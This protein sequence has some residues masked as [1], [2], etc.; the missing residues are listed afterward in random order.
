MNAPPAVIGPSAVIGHEYL[1]GIPPQPSYRTT[2]HRKLSDQPIQSDPRKLSDVMCYQ[3]MFLHDMQGMVI[4]HNFF[5][6]VSCFRADCILELE[7]RANDNTKGKHDELSDL[8]ENRRERNIGRYGLVRCRSDNERD[9]RGYRNRRS[10]GDKRN[11]AKLE[12][13]QRSV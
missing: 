13:L 4:G 5:L 7:C 1:S 8:R 3:T 9:V 12:S 11:Q 6:F 10:W 2:T